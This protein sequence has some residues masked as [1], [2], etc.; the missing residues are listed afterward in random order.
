[1]A[2]PGCL[3]RCRPRG[4]VHRRGR[5][6]RLPPP[7][8]RP[9]RGPG[10]PS[11]ARRCAREDRRGSGRPAGAGTRPGRR[12][13]C[14]RARARPEARPGTPGGLGPRPREGHRSARERELRRRGKAPLP[15]AGR[16]GGAASS[17]PRRRPRHPLPRHFH[18]GRRRVPR[19]DGRPSLDGRSSEGRD[20]RASGRGR[21]EHPSLPAPGRLS[22]TL[23]GEPASGELGPPPAGRP[24]ATPGDRRSAA[25]AAVGGRLGAGRGP[26][27]RRG[28]TGGRPA[29]GG[30]KEE[31][32]EEEE[33]ESH[34]DGGPARRAS[35]PG[36]D[37]RC[38]A[39][40]AP[41]ARTVT[42]ARGAP[43]RAE[44]PPPPARSSLSPEIP[45]PPGGFRAPLSL[46][47]GLRRA[48]STG[49]ACGLPGADRGRRAGGPSVRTERACER[50]R[51][52]GRP[53]GPA[54]RQAP[55]PTDLGFPGAARRVMGITP[56]DRQSASFMDQPG[57]RHPRR[58]RGA[59]RERPDAPGPPARAPPTLTAPALSPLRPAGAA[60]RTRRWRHGGDGRRRRR[61]AASRPGGAWGGE[62]RHARGTPLAP[63]PTPAAGPSRDA[64]GKEPGPLRSFSFATRMRAAREKP[65]KESRPAEG[66]L[67][68]H[69]KS[70]IDRARSRGRSRANSDKGPTATVL[71]QRRRPPKPHLRANSDKG[72]TAT[73]LGQ[74]RRPPKPRLRSARAGPAWQPSPPGISGSV[75]AATTEV[76]E[77]PPPRPGQVRGAPSV[78]C[79]VR[80]LQ[81]TLPANAG[82]RLKAE[83]GGWF[84]QR[85]PGTG[86]PDPGLRSF[87]G[88]ADR[89]RGGPTAAEADRQPKKV[90][91]E[92]AP[93]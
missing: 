88:R 78:G 30:G 72:P 17:E 54:T 47:L 10:F 7:P 14:A 43:G 62:R 92:W 45:P 9:S 85:G 18:I 70:L 2:P 5:A 71:G 77:A 11:V 28:R 83:E 1:M 68:R 40:S 38:S 58:R 91:A 24:H 55:S 67:R 51:A 49:R 13:R 59:A 76:G 36:R 39:G 42:G 81:K 65:R 37:A 90:P 63:R 89:R 82:P 64:A 12:A 53:D 79:R 52:R 87:T 61:P 21:A 48:A 6:R 50:R 46:S 4:S 26:A 69:P 73:V 80:Q 93:A 15:G 19:P 31:E 57:S 84:Q 86:R 27:P 44:R 60:S 74:R 34:R 66:P 33:E 3:P 29:R 75:R 35:R 41:P 16:A 56:P 20:G 23:R 25:P 32:E 8:R 22:R